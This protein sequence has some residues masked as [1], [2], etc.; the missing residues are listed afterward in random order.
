MQQSMNNESQQVIS[1]SVP[2]FKAPYEE[3]GSVSSELYPTSL[4]GYQ[5]NHDSGGNNQENEDF[6]KQ[7]I[8]G[9]EIHSQFNLGNLNKLISKMENESESLLNL[10]STERPKDYYS[11]STIVEPESYKYEEGESSDNYNIQYK[12]DEEN[13]VRVKIEDEN[14][15]E[16]CIDAYTPEEEK[17]VRVKMENEDFVEQFTDQYRTDEENTVSEKIEHED[18]VEKLFP[19]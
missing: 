12:I 11:N 4:E 17:N 8:P 19:S 10:L 2:S 18:I 15:V 3:H 6:I 5:V 14:I 7:E 16:Q 1:P 13:I 9:V